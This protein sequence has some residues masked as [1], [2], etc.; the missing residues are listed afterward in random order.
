LK[1]QFAQTAAIKTAD[2]TF[3][4]K[5]VTCRNAVWN[6]IIHLRVERGWSMNK[7]RKDA[8]EII[9]TCEA[10]FLSTINSDNFPETRGVLNIL[11][12]AVDD[13]LELYFTTDANSPKVEQIKKNSNASVY[14]Y[15]YS[16]NTL[17]NMTLFGKFETVTDKTLKAQLW[18]DSFR[19]YYKNGKDDESYGILKFIPT[20]YK[21]YVRESGDSRKKNEGKF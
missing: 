3:Y 2:I 1:N 17:K 9:R 13:R 7:A 11:N 16:E 15:N 4:P 6:V 12:R 18:L 20:G 21:Y 5:R 14:Y 10:A 19:E 8:V